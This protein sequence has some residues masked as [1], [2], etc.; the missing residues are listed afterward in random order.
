MAVGNSGVMPTRLTQV[1]IDAADPA[2]LARFWSA[3]LDWTVAFEGPGEVEI[4]PPADDAG[5]RGQLPLTF[6][7]VHDDKVG[8]N[9]VHLDLA[10]R[11]DAHQAE[12]VARLEALGARRVDVGQG[13]DVSWV[14]MA[15]PDGNE[16]C[17]VSHAGS[18]GADP[19]SAF[20]DRAPVAAV[21]VD[22]ADP[23]GVAPFWAAATGWTVH[24]EDGNHLWLRGAEDG[25]PWLD[26][27]RNDDPKIAKLRVHLDVSPFPDDDQDAEVERLLAAGGHR[28]DIGQ[29]A[30]TWQV[31]TDPQG[32]ELCVL[33]PR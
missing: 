1:V 6:V 11:S 17:V 25:G 27:R 12:V 18:V 29:G 26:L 24:G 33:S 14:V 31:L 30:P 4:A 2:A 3:A 20:G 8:K 22:C 32:N 21:V 10:S 15:D 9:R 13:D 7:E 28:T 5:Q 19:A 16:M 23:A